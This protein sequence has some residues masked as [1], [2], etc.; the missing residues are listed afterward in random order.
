MSRDAD[1]CAIYETALGRLM[2]VFM[3]TGMGPRE[4]W[5]TCQ[6]ALSKAESLPRAAEPAS[7]PPPYEATLRDIIRYCRN[8]GPNAEALQFIQQACEEVL[9]GGNPET[10]P[11]AA[12]HHRWVVRLWTSSPWKP[13]SRKCAAATPSAW[14]WRGRTPCRWRV[15]R[16]ARFKF[17]QAPGRMAAMWS[18]WA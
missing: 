1:K 3:S 6:S 4:V 10:L 16:L 18:S 8:R 11:Q 12:V 17:N 14:S 9:S 5:E 2:T 13:S 15:Y 7:A